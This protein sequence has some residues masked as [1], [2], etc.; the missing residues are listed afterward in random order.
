ME[1][2]DSLMFAHVLGQHLIWQDYGKIGPTPGLPKGVCHWLAWL[3]FLSH[4]E[5]FMNHE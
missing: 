4:H 2:T 1:M 3:S 5:L